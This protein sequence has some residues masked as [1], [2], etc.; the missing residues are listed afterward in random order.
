MDVRRR[1]S[2]F[3]FV[4]LPF[5]PAFIIAYSTRLNIQA[6]QNALGVGE[7]ADDLSDRLR[8]LA[9]E[10]RDRQDLIAARECRVVHQINH[11]NVILSFQILF[12]NVLEIFEGSERAWSLTGYVKTQVPATRISACSLRWTAV[13]GLLSFLLRGTLFHLAAPFRAF[14][15][16][17][18][19]I[20]IPSS[21]LR[22][23]AISRR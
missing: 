13:A 22:S 16:P 2:Y 3:H 20:R 10:R 11:F 5:V 7:I 4:A 6:N 19:S 8:Q 17:F 14:L 21:A 12:T 15:A 18:S 23:R 9:H 1:D